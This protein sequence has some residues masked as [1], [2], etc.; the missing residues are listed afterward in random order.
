MF[1]LSNSATST[2]ATALVR[3]L[4]LQLSASNFNSCDNDGAAQR[5]RAY[6]VLRQCGTVQLQRLVTL[7]WCLQCSL[8]RQQ[9]QR[10]DIQ[11]HQ[12]LRAAAAVPSTTGSDMLH[13]HLQSQRH[14]RYGICIEHQHQTP[15]HLRSSM[16]STYASLSASAT[17][18]RWRQRQ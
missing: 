4:S 11:R 7:S 9:K 12:Q 1:F 13:R 6:L 2:S 15:H 14:L 17:A 5:Q 8:Q 18:T 16:R 10:C 3:T